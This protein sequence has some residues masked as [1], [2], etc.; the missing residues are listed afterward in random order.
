MTKEQRYLRA[1]C[2]N[3][4]A[5]LLEVQKCELEMDR[6][7]AEYLVYGRELKEDY[8]KAKDR[9]DK[10][11]S[12]YSKFGGLRNRELNARRRH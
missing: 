8:A 4:R 7:G 9:L 6:I 5:A 3:T 1:L 12:D 2:G 11:Y 10:A